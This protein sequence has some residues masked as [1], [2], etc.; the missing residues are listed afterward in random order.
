MCC[1]TLSGMPSTTQPIQWR[2]NM[3]GGAIGLQHLGVR[4]LLIE[5]GSLWEDD[6]FAVFL[7]NRELFA[8][9]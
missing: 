9:L 3:R 2:A 1:H 8:M 6:Y 4:T 5:P 7:V